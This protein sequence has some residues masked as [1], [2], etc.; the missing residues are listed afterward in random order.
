MQKTFSFLFLP[1]LFFSI[2]FIISAKTWI[3]AWMGLEINLMMFIPMLCNQ[4]NKLYSES[5][6][7]YFLVQAL[8]SSIFLYSI[9]M[10]YFLNFK[11]T[12]EMVKTITLLALITKMG[13]APF[14]FWFTSVIEGM[15]WFNSLL[16]MTWQKMG[17]LTL[18]M[19]LKNSNFLLFSSMLSACIGGLGG[20]NQ[21]SIRKIMAF[22]SIS[23]IGWMMA[24]IIYNKNNLIIYFFIY[25]FIISSLISLFKFF[26]LYQINQLSNMYMC[27]IF[28]KIG[29]IINLLSL[30]G[31][32]PLLGFLPK[33]ILIN[34]LINLNQL[35]LLSVLV[36]SS[37]LTLYMYM[38]LSLN[39]F[40]LNFW[41]NNWLN[42]MIL[43]KP[44]LNYFMM[45]SFI[46]MMGLFMIIFIL[47]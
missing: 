18:L 42:Y 39:M 1:C 22:S 33:W 38:R 32:P 30:G 37:L 14:H 20:I 12:D 11:Y 29:L 44:L 16:L 15:N 8:A 2:F 19:N 31:M 4:K 35:L 26:N 17:P 41:T 7:K 13:G 43:S 25:T 6:M 40:M 36:L 5:A 23:H 45:S 10:L 28:L 24:T 47:T 34:Y 9:I 46:S 21:N 27:S 3:M